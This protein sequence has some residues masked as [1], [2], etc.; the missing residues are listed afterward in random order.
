MNEDGIYVVYVECGPLSEVSNREFEPTADRNF[1]Q[2]VSSIGSAFGQYNDI[3]NYYARDEAKRLIILE[4]TARIL[5]LIFLKKKFPDITPRDYLLSQ[6]NGGQECITSIRNELRLFGC[7]FDDLISIIS[8][9]LRHLKVE[10]PG[11]K[12]LIFAIDESNVAAINF[13][14]VIFSI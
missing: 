6:L 9:A 12:S 8:S 14:V 13:S 11:Q 5:Y 1:A 7:D 2:L 10:L 4:F 3:I